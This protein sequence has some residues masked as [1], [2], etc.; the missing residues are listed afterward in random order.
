[1]TLWE[2][3]NE[4]LNFLKDIPIEDLRMHVGF[5]Y[6]LG[7]PIETDYWRAQQFRHGNLE[8]AAQIISDFK[9]ITQGLDEEYIWS[10]NDLNAELFSIDYFTAKNKKYY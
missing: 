9:R 1:M 10:E 4:R 3:W 7:S 8:S 6:F 5:L 2:K